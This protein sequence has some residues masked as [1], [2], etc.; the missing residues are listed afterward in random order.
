MAS[1]RNAIRVAGLQGLGPAAV[2]RAA[3]A[4]LTVEQPGRFVTAFVGRI[5]AERRQ[6]TYALAGHPPPLLR[7]AAAVRALELGDPPLGVWDGEFRAHAIELRAPWL[8]I[9]YTD[10][11]IERTGDVIAGERLLRE[12]VGDDGIIHAADPAAF[13]QRR[14]LRGVVRD[15]TAILTLRVDGL[16]HWRFGA[17]DALQAEPARRRLHAWLQERTTGDFASA[18]LICGELIGNVVRHA[19]GPIDVNV[20][21]ER[22]RVHLV[23]QSNGRAITV[24]PALPASPLREGG[25]GLFIIDELGSGYTTRE[26]PLFGN[27]TSVDLPLT[28]IRS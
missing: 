15:D 28:T 22:E 9:A 12:V 13:V 26:L 21:L 20:T 7:D 27:Q 8:L 2:L 4:L 24:R 3:N 11:L 6:L 23:V 16:E 19:P 18:E 17:P 5:D 14:L 1:M 10:G 25:R